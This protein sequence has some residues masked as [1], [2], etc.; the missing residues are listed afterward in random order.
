[1]DKKYKKITKEQVLGV[2]IHIHINFMNPTDVI[3]VPN[4]AYILKT[5]KYQV[6]KHIDVL[7]KEGLIQVAYFP[8]SL[9]DEEL[10]LP[11][12][13]FCITEKVEELEQYKVAEEN[14][15]KIMKEVFWDLI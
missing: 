10:S 13:G 7:K 8:T 4:I 12:K 14:E 3:S 11:I 15:R 5:S 9:I 6:R 1:M 2:L